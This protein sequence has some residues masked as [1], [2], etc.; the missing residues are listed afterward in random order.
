MKLGLLSF[1]VSFSLKFCLQHVMQPTGGSRLKEIS[2]SN[3]VNDCNTTRDI[4]EDIA[5]LQILSKSGTFILA[6]ISVA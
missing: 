1:N 3:A 5:Q 4:P 2:S 6:V